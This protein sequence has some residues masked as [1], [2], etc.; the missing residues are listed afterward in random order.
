MKIKRITAKNIKRFTNIEITGLPI[1][2]KLVLVVGPNGSGKSSLLESFYVWYKQNTGFG[3]NNDKSYYQ[4]EETEAYNIHNAVQIDFHETKPITKKIMYFRSAYRNDPDFRVENFSRIGSASEQLKFDKL[5]DN[6]QAVSSNYQRL[7]H[8]T[9]TKLYDSNY[10]TKTVSD[11]RNELI[12]KIKE[13]MQRVFPDLLLNNIGDPL[14]DGTFK[15]QKGVVSS[16]LYKNLSGGEKAAFDLLLD[17]VLKIDEYQDTIFIIDEPETHMH[18][19]LQAALLKEILNILP[20]NSQLWVTTHSFGIIQEAREYE[21]INPGSVSII[22]FADRDFDS[23]VIIY[24]S[25][26]DKVLWE[27]FLSISLGDISKMIAPRQVFICEGDYTGVR[28]K[29]F[30]SDIYSRIFSNEFPDVV[31][32]SGGSCT[33]IVKDDNP[34]FTVLKNLL[35][36]SQINRIIDRD[37]YSEDEVNTYKSSSIKVL[38]LRNIESYLFS[39]EIIEIYVKSIDEGKVAQVLEEKEAA[40]ARSISR[41]NSS[42]DLK[43]ASGEIYNS[44]KKILLLTKCGNNTDSFMRDTLTRFVTPETMVYQKLKEDLF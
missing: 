42:D 2:T 23:N 1:T 21:H 36:S 27:K 16:Y 25:K 7:I 11:L 35:R 43:S 20:E 31:F 9:M 37:D 12:G 40:L 13:S 8:N 5:I 34:V 15:F 6:D 33:D 38:S 14:S 19:S 30:D 17:L 3:I 28:R 29:D 24:P 22:D 44:I 32:I 26:L 4:K 18:T 41:G 10:D 39:D